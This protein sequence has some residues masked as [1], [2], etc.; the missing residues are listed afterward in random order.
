MPLAGGP[1]QHGG[2]LGTALALALLALLAPLAL[3]RAGEARS[4]KPPGG[5]SYFGVADTGKIKHFRNFAEEVGAHPAVM[6]TFHTWGYHPW[7]ALNRW[8]RTDTRGMLSISTSDSYDGRELITPKQIA[9]GRGD[10][11]PLLL[12]RRFAAERETVYIRLLPE[13]NGHWNPYS[14]FNSDG[15]SRGD[16]HSTHWFRQ[17][18]RRFTLI[19]RGGKRSK[20][21]HEL[22]RLGLRPIE[23][24]E[25][26]GDYAPLDIPKRLPHADVA[27][28]WVPQTHGSPNISA[29]EPAAY[30]PGGKYVDWV[31]AD[32][33]AKFPHFD[34]LSDFYND[35]RHKPFL[36]GEWSPW[37]GDDGSF[38]RRLFGWARRHE[39]TRMLVYYTG[40]GHPVHDI[41]NYPGARQRLRRELNRERF[42]PYAPRARRRPEPPPDGGTPAG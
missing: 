42:D 34:W 9:K 33:Y 19:V 8:A 38:V 2:R 11:Y 30:W 27:L 31:G 5:R 24:V 35:Y 21:N 18:W 10:E 39:R 37:G 41:S 3:A 23:R 22:D 4:Y 15:S 7:R 36:I 20:I 17:A 16:D 1:P 6:Q 25:N 32:I 29:N 12:N 26:A 40:F 13:M 14:A 28:A